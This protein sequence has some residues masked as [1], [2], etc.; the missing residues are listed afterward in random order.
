M[1]IAASTIIAAAAPAVIGAVGGAL[2][3]GSSSSK[4]SGPISG[5]GNQAGGVLGQTLND[6]QS[7]VNA[8]P[9]Q[10]DVSAGLTGQRDL[11]SML[12]QYQQGGSMPSADD[13]SQQE[14]L[15]GRLFA[16]RRAAVTGNFKEQEQ[17]YAQQAA[18]QG[19]NPLDPVF[20]NKQA[21]EQ[22]KQLNQLGAEQSSFATQQAI[23][24]PMQRLGFAQQRAQ[25]LGGLAS[26]AL[27]NRQMLSGMGS[28]IRGQEMNFAAGQGSTSR[29]TGGGLG[30]AISGGLAGIGQGIGVLNGAGAFGGPSQSGGPSLGAVPQAKPGGNIFGVNTNF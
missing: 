3:G 20:R 14:G 23:N 21:Q 4:S 28:Q 13:I 30:G 8:G 27:A 7:L 6:T 24:Q 2:S 17:Q 5:L 29:Q 11:A 25:V 9:G 10:S 22:E 16:G 18:L 12:Q 1:G 26:Q 15:A 19:R